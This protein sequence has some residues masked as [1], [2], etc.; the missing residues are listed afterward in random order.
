[1]IREADTEVETTLDATSWRAVTYCARTSAPFSRGSP[2]RIGMYT[3][4]VQ[5]QFF[6]APARDRFAVD[7]GPS[8]PELFTIPGRIHARSV[9]AF[10]EIRKS[11][12][13]AD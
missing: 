12:L 2:H 1:M 5:G 7:V 10:Y 8:K 6:N 3:T 4:L 13:I 11:K 9:R